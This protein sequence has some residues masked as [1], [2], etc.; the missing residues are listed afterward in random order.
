MVI[1]KFEK[2]FYRYDL[3]EPSDEWNSEP[4]FLFDDVDDA[5]TAAQKALKTWN[6]NHSGEIHKRF[7]ITMVKIKE[8]LN[9]FEHTKVYTGRGHSLSEN[10]KAYQAKLLELGYDGYSFKENNANYLTYCI[11]NHNKMYPPQKV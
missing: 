6:D 1:E 9:I 8:R 3:N 10:G 11:F 7:Y 4:L 2:A 5:I